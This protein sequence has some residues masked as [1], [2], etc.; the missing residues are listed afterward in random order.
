MAGTGLLTNPVYVQDLAVWLPLLTVAAIAG[1][2]GKPWGVLVTAAMLTMFVLEC[3]SISVDQWFGVNA[4]PTSKVS[5]MTMVPAFAV[6][7]TIIA[8]PLG[9]FLYRMGRTAPGPVTIH[10]ARS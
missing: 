1:L 6:V 4:D 8:V 10:D 2:R 3:I 9:W 5:S 7:A